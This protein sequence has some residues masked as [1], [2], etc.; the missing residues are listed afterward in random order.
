ML[1]TLDPK[2][3]N[4]KLNPVADDSLDLVR[5]ADAVGAEAVESSGPPE[6]AMACGKSNGD[7]YLGFR[8]Q[9]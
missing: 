2:F 1:S 5:G 9:G 7:H 6:N 8:V 3:L 4:P